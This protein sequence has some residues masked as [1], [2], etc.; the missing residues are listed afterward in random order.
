[1][2]KYKV[3]ICNLDTS[4]LKTIPAKEMDEL[5]YMYQHGD[6]TAKEK[7]IYGNLKLVLSLVQ[8][9]SHRHENMDDLF[10]IGCVG[11]I[12]AIDN[13]DLS[14]GVRFSTYA[15]PMIIGEIK[16]FL[17]DFSMVKVSRN[18][19]EIAYKALQLKEEYLNTYQKELS[20]EKVAEMMELKPY[21][22]QE[23][24]EAM[25]SVSSIFDPVYSDNG[26]ELTLMDQAVD[27]KDKTQSLNDYIALYDGIRKLTAKEKLIIN[28]RYYANKTQTEVAEELGISQAQVSRL[29]KLAIDHLKRNM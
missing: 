25:Q 21:Q 14:I 19:K 3:D 4:K 6:L 11:L 13:F 2:S 22:V 15:V 7:L 16:R 12:K 18:L 23:A 20:T 26:E 5:F 10:Q 1:M 9:Y 17:R 24:L 28:Q 8:K 29:E 27:L